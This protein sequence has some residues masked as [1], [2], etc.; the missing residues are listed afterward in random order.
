MNDCQYM[1]IVLLLYI[2]TM[3]VYEEILDSSMLNVYCR[4]DI[5]SGGKH[6]CI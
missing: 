6:K 1:Y 2:Y 4:L 5:L 3:N